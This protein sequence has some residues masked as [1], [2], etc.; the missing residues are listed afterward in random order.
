[1]FSLSLLLQ[2]YFFLFEYRDI[3]QSAALQYRAF[4]SDIK[5]KKT[6]YQL[7]LCYWNEMVPFSF[8]FFFF[9]RLRTTWLWM[10]RCD[11]MGF[12]SGL[13]VVHTYCIR[14]ASSPLMASPSIKKLTGISQLKTENVSQFSIFSCESSDRAVNVQWNM[15]DLLPEDGLTSFGI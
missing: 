8:S 9:L 6:K 10:L 11:Q 13:F 14:D 15:D 12:H 2:M 1:M 3:L 5:I 7:F 4:C